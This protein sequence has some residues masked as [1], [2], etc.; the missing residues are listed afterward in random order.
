VIARLFNTVGP[1]QSGQY[2]MVIPRF[3]ERALTGRPLEIHGDG[4][5]TRCFCH[6]ADTVQALSGLMRSP[7]TS[8]EIYNVG[9]Q[10]PIRIIELARRVLEMT[11]S[12]SELEFVPY[13]QVYGQGIEDMHHRIPATDKI[14]DAV[15]WRAKLD[16][17]LVL[18]DV[19]KHARTKGLRLEA[20]PPGADGQRDEARSGASVASTARTAS[21]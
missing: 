1:R 21:E 11:H 14:A 13:D 15:G 8:G 18:A 2:G 19:I 20:E 10:Q 3:V 6:V 4:T 9:S 17:D 5:Q 12:D 16:L 7:E